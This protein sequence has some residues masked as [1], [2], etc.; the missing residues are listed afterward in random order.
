[1]DQALLSSQ[2]VSQRSCLCS[3]CHQRDICLP[4]ALTRD[5]LERIDGRIV[6]GRQKLSRGDRLFQV[7][8][9]FEAVFA[10]WTGH[11]KTS[12]ASKDGREQVTA[13]Q[14][15]GDLVGLD[16]IG[17]GRHEVDAVALDDAQVCVIRYAEFGRLALEAGPLLQ[18]FHRAMSRE[19]VRNHAVMLLL[20]NMNA[21]ERLAAF[22]IDQ[23]QRQRQRGLSGTSIMLRMSREEI[24]SYLGLK[25]ETVSRTF[26]K[27][28]ANGLLFVRHRQIQVLDPVGLQLIVDGELA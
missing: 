21:E 18:Q 23:T 13:F 26:S 10:V 25:I 8:D 1:M 6:T 5:Q 16:G 20:G 17:S 27:F 4:M 15:A 11:F 12:V 14:M 22:L 9:H 3:P 24:G 19:I 7:G 2:F 28:Q